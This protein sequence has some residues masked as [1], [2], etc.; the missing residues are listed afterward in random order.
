MTVSSTAAPAV[1]PPAAARR[2]PRRAAAALAAGLVLGVVPGV[3]LAGG[4]DAATPTTLTLRADHR[5][6]TA[7]SR[8]VLRAHLNAADRSVTFYEKHRGVSNRTIYSGTTDAHGNVAIDGSAGYTSTFTA[9]FAG[10]STYAAS[11]ATTRITVRVRM[12]I[13]AGGGTKHKGYRTYHQSKKATVATA[14]APSKRGHKV[15]FRLQERRKGHY[16][17]LQTRRYKIGKKS[18]VAIT[19]RGVAGHRYRVRAEYA[20]DSLNAR[21]HTAWTYSRF[22]R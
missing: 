17:T 8:V 1:A 13:A 22:V 2:T 9:K 4:A 6:Y 3:V 18:A 15:L 16:R 10:D 21:N 7:G 11:S 12:A 14:V 5:T 20:G 19:Y